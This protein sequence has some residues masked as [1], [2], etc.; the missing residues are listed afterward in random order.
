MR[1]SIELNKYKNEK[2]YRQAQSILAK[3]FRGELVKDG[4]E[5]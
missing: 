2:L 3:A 1:D 4:E 5:R